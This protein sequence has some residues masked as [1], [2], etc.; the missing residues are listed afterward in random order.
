M[1]T[2]LE[3]RPHAIV[4]R[5]AA[6]VSADV[7]GEAVILSIDNGRY[8]NMN[9]VGTRIWE[10][11][12]QPIS[13]AALIDL[14]MREFEVERQDCEAEVLAFLGELHADRLVQISEP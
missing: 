13:V 11:V 6:Q 10:A 12:E 2:K 4:V 7:D 14:L 1:A 5:T 8:Y 3:L 9:A